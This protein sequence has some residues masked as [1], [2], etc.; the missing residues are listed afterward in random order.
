MPPICRKFERGGCKL[1][2]HKLLFLVAF[3]LPVQTLSANET[4]FE[5]E[6][7]AYYSNVSWTKG[8]HNQEVPVVQNLKE[9][10][11]YKQILKNSLQPDFIVFEAS[12]NPMPILGVYLKDVWYAGE[13]SRKI[14]AQLVQA[15]TTGFEEPYALSV[16]AGRVLRFAPPEGM[17]TTGDNKGYIG[18][19][20]SVGTQ[21]I[22]RNTLI[23]DRWMELEWKIKGQR[24]TDVQYL[25]WSFRGGA[26]FHSHPEISDSFMLGLRR[27][28][29]DYLK[30]EDTF[31]RDIGFEYQLDML[32]SNF[33]PSRQT[34]IIDKHWPLQQ[35]KR[36]FS[37]GFGVVWQG[38]SRYLGDLAKGHDKWTWVLRPN[39]KF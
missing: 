18:Y 13:D 20:L 27:N 25:S 14:D 26:K 28:R 16:F 23:A 34:L 10:D 3:I 7:D 35:G 15:V 19:L 24:E 17:S 2:I 22:Q 11:I 5:Y 4:M 12:I 30:S 29:I 31:L 39:M 32:Q 33:A 6:L 9:L 1:N 37:L 36:T 21:H 8:F 38:A